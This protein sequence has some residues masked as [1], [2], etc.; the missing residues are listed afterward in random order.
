MKLSRK[1]IWDYE[2]KKS[3]LKKPGFLKWY[4][5]RKI[6]Y[7]DWE[8]LDRRSSQRNRQ[9]RFG[10]AFYLVRRIV[11]GLIFAFLIVFFIIFIKGR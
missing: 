10:K 8:A 9:K 6:E 2:I 1:Y 4:L 3:D 5:E 7:G 11:C